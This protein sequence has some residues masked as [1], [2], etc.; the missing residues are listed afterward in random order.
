M[1]SELYEAGERSRREEMPRRTLPSR[2]RR[3]PRPPTAQRSPH[4]EESA[5]APLADRNA[6]HAGCRLLPRWYR[7][8]RGAGGD[9]VTHR[10]LRGPAGADCTGPDADPAD[11]PAGAL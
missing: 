5:A 2:V 3:A 8:F 4:D 7:R 6:G 11:G 10:A 1:P 9:S